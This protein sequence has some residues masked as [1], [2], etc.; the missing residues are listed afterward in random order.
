MVFELNIHVANRLYQTNC[1]ARRIKLPK[2]PCA[3]V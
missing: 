1:Q 2:T 3:F